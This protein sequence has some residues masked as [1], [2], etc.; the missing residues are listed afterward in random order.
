[1][2]TLAEKRERQRL[3]TARYRARHHERLRL[4]RLRPHRP[5]PPAIDR[6]WSRVEKREDGC[7][8]WTGGLGSQGYGNIIDDAKKRIYAHR[9]SYSM[10]RGDIPPGLELDHLCRVRR[11]V[12][13]DHL[14]VVTRKVNSDRGF[15]PSG[16]NSRKTHCIRGHPFDAAN[17]AIYIR[18][19]R[20]IRQCKQCGRIRLRHW[21]KR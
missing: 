2:I 19:G 16:I 6:F 10:F 21:R 18:N 5:L 4:S 1:M 12:N 15:G 14:E 9:F 13:P 11:C 3:A 20:Q 7:W 17:T 8:A